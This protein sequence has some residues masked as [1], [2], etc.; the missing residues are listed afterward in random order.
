M[1]ASLSCESLS[2]VNMDV[3]VNVNSTKHL[4]NSPNTLCIYTT[5]HACTLPG[6]SVPPTVVQSTTTPLLG[7]R[8]SLRPP[9]GL[10]QASYDRGGVVTE[11]YD[12]VPRYDPP[13][14]GS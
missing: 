5:H 8:R 1:L 4:T 2:G 14:E 3:N 13:Y 9:L 7:L 10:P 11:P 12:H 6:H